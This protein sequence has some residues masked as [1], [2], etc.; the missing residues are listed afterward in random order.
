MV[1]SHV[2]GGW[3]FLRSLDWASGNTI[4]QYCELIVE[5]SGFFWDILITKH[6][7]AASNIENVGW[8]AFPNTIET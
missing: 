4:E 2:Q 3:N 8:T 1:R 6:A 7:F 5:R